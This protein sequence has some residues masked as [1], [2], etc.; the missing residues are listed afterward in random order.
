MRSS[1][2]ICSAES[3]WSQWTQLGSKHAWSLPTH[4]E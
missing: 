3:I 2:I 1:G 4:R